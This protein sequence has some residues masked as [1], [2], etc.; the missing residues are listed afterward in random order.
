MVAVGNKN[1]CKAASNAQLQYSYKNIFSNGFHIEEVLILTELQFALYFFTTCLMCNVIAWL[2]LDYVTVS[3]LMFF[4]FISS[5]AIALIAPLIY[6][7]SYLFIN[8][9]DGET[10]TWITPATGIVCLLMAVFFNKF[11]LWWHKF[12]S[13]FLKI[14]KSINR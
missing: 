10:A 7:T 4:I 13:I 1:V 5:I 8:F 2:Y 3:F 14:V 6:I 11:Y 12:T 9:H